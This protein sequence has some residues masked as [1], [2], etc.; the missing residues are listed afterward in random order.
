MLTSAIRKVLPSFGYN[1]SREL[2]H[3]AME[4][5]KFTPDIAK[6][7]EYTWQLYF[8]IDETKKDHFKHHLLGVDAQYR[9]P[10]FT[11]HNFTYW[12]PLVPF[13]SPVAMREVGSKVDIPNFPPAAKIK[14]QVYLIRPQRFLELDPYKQ[15]TVEY[16]RERVK[17]IVPYRQVEFLKDHNLD[18]AFGVQEAFCR[19]D[20]EGSS[21]KT[22]RETTCIIR[23]WMYIGK[24]EF[25]DPLLTA[26]D[27]KSVEY[28]FSNKRRWCEKYYNIRRP[29]L[30]K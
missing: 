4:A 10:A 5:S 25:Y 11:Q 14:G 8:A 26:F 7:E 3:K 29:A 23:A 9:F 21:I 6:L 19:S 16:H 28:H 15:N 2:V 18:P 27:Y 22:S 24:P 20:Y 1:D 30:Q 13:M 12:D 17:L